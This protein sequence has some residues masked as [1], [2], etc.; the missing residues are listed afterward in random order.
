MVDKSVLPPWFQGEKMQP[1][2]FGNA[3]FFVTKTC[4]KTVPTDSK[5]HKKTHKMEV[6]WVIH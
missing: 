4:G 6:L 3:T 2:L 5:E 1:F